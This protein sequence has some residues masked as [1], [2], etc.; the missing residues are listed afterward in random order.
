MNFVAVHMP[1]EPADIIAVER[2]IAERDIIRSVYS[3]SEFDRYSLGAYLEEV[4]VHGSK[5]VALLDRNIFSDIIAVVRGTL[6]TR[7]KIS[8]TQRA[9]CALL[10]FF[11][12]S[13]ILIEPGM[14]IYEYISSHNFK[15]FF[16]YS[17][18]VLREF[19]SCS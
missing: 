3:D 12:L 19:T 13:D 10:A 14:A 1:V 17:I 15:R 6:T 16:T 5:F 7:K 4:H 9:A 8:E 2:L 18:S 11:Q